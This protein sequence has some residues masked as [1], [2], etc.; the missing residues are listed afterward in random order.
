MKI[1]DFFNTHAKTPE[2]VMALCKQRG[3][4]LAAKRS[5]EGRLPPAYTLRVRA[6]EGAKD[7]ANWELLEVAF[8]SE[9]NSVNHGSN[10]V[11]T[12]ELMTQLNELVSDEDSEFR[13]LIPVPIEKTFVYI[14]ISDFTKHKPMQQAIII[15]SLSGV[16]SMIEND[17]GKDSGIEAKL[18]IGD[19]YIVVF[20]EAWKAVE[21]GVRLA[22]CVEFLQAGLGFSGLPIDYHYRMSAH[23]GPVFRFHDV[24]RNNWNYVGEGINGG[25]RVLDVMG[26]E[27]DDVFYISKETYHAVRHAPNVLGG[28]SIPGAIIANADNRGRKE[29]KHKRAW[30]VY[31]LNHERIVSDSELLEEFEREA[32]EGGGDD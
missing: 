31:Q 14:D 4:Y 23:T 16:I 32:H 2:E 22:H 18:S 24:G 1:S 27:I 13:H 3:L 29:D 9:G 20:K 15:N 17:M 8:D 26:K 5:N 11:V 10:I 21:F 19:G 7:G 28:R 25:Q 12:A 30:R 6:K